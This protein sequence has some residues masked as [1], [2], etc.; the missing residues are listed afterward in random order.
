MSLN[1]LRLFLVLSL[2]CWVFGCSKKDSFSASEI[3]AAKAFVNSQILPLY[4]KG[5]FNS[6]IDSQSIEA[7][8]IYR[9]VV[10]RLRQEGA[11]RLFQWR[12]PAIDFAGYPKYFG[13]VVPT[14][15]P[16]FYVCTDGCPTENDVSA[17][18]YYHEIDQNDKGLWK[19]RGI[20]LHDGKYELYQGN[21]CARYE[22]TSSPR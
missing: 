4:P 1:L 14:D 2:S 6:M 17:Q 15:R 20:E 21:P 9:K 18:E 7:C 10:F 11:P 3:E 22:S 8:E 19:S 16:L 12:F 13:F 5:G